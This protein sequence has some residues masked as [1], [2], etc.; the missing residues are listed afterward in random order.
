MRINVVDSIMGSGKSS[1]AIQ[2]MKDNEDSNFIY[3]TPFLSEVQRVKSSCDNRKFYEPIQLGKGKQDN[4]HKLL[5]NEKDI[6]STHALFKMSNDITSELIKSGNYILIL[7]EVMDVLDKVQLKKDD[8][9]SMLSLGLI[10]I[11][12]G[13]IV[14]NEDKI[15]YEGKY[16]SIKSMALSNTL[17]I[18]NNTVLMWT[19]PADI[20]K[21]FKEVYVL[22]YMF[23]GQIQRYYYDLYDIKYDYF[24]IDKVDGKYTMCEY[25][26]NK[27]SIE[28]IKGLIN[29]FEDVKLN[30]IGDN[31]YSLSST[32]FKTDKNIPLINK[33][34]K[35]VYN[36]FAQKTKA[37]S[38][39]LIWTTFKSAQSKLNGKGYTRGFVSVN[40]R[41]TNE[42]GTRHNMAY[43]ANIFLNPLVKNFFVDHKVVVE[44]D[45]Y[46]ISEMLQ[47]IWRSAVRNNEVVNIYIPSSRMRNLLKDWLDLK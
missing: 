23:K 36:Y 9:P 15:D 42:Y 8:V 12:N 5:E 35:N 47:W 34:Q 38:S 28:K 39:D 19:F 32:W 43:C 24:S 41:A 16:D 26:D 25:K 6:A 45:I 30:S 33:L 13:V 7:D 29:I 46:A 37:K 10:T 44:E 31:E 18:V 1:W 2:Y 4:L 40:A 3:I 17:F 14:W 21:S 11:D 20:F 27:D 22:T